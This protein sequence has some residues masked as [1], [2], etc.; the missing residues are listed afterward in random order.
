[1]PTWLIFALLWAG[2]YLFAGAW[3]VTVVFSADEALEQEQDE[4]GERP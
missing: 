1:M 4:A 2:A 3:A